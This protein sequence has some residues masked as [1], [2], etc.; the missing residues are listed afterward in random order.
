MR[1]GKFC[2][3]IYNKY[4]ITSFNMRKRPLVYTENDHFV[5]DDFCDQGYP[6]ILLGFQMKN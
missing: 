2:S 6:K 4:T 1:Y 3:N 5:A